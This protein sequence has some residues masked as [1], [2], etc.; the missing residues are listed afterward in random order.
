[1]GA[2]GSA[3]GEAL[4]QGTL[5]LSVRGHIHPARV[6]MEECAQELS[7]LHLTPSS[8]GDEQV[9]FLLSVLSTVALELSPAFVAA[10]FSCEDVPEAAPS[11]RNQDDEHSSLE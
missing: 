10:L 5:L 6:G 9:G 4:G 3:G 11:L 2:E 1:M 7:K 8:E